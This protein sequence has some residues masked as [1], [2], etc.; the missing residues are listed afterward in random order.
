[1]AFQRFIGSDILAEQE[2]EQRAA[3]CTS[4]ENGKLSVLECQTV[5]GAW[6]DSQTERLGFSTSEGTASLS[7]IDDTAFLFEEE[8]TPG[9]NHSPLSMEPL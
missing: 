7:L 2:I 4:K 5:I 8:L 1:M 9:A 3:F 6:L